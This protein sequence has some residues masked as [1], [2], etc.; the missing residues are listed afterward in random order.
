M[1]IF[2]MIL[3]PVSFSDISMHLT[4]VFLS[5]SVLISPDVLFFFSLYLRVFS[6]SNQNVKRRRRRDIL[7]VQLVRIFELLADAGVISQ[8]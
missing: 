6:L 8:M 2:L 5:E 7:R 3:Y 4:D 1:H